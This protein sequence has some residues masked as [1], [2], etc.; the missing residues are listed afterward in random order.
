MVKNLAGFDFDLQRFD[1]VGVG[2][3][4]EYGGKTLVISDE[5]AD[6]KA[7]A[8]IQKNDSKELAFIGDVTADFKDSSSEHST[9]DYTAIGNFA[10]GGAYT[11]VV[12]ASTQKISALLREGQI[13]LRPNVKIQYF[14]FSILNAQNSPKNRVFFIP[15][16]KR[17]MT[18]LF[19]PQ[20]YL[21][22]EFLF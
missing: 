5:V 12:A 22:R 14:G 3:T 20:N 6:G 13:F 9:D 15:S 10:V 1:A 21:Y 7:G 16:K 19:R 18:P 8:I 2:F 17:V 4:I 11:A